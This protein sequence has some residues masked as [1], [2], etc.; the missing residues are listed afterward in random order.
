MD[1]EHAKAGG[2]RAA[3]V[4][5][6]ASAGGVAW[7]LFWLL[8]SFGELPSVWELIVP[9]GTIACGS[10]AAV[11]AVVVLRQQSSQRTAPIV[12]FFLGVALITWGIALVPVSVE[13]V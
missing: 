2:S 4:S 12:G 1:R 6:A 11:S 3:A 7:S 8:E 9:A 13:R 10:V 5:V